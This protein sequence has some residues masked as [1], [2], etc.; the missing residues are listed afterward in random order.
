M[1]VYQLRRDKIDRSFL[2]IHIPKTGGT[3]IERY[4]VSLGLA[5]FF[6]PASYAPI[7]SVLKVPPAHFDYEMCDKLFLLDRIY[8]FAIVRHPVSRM[9]SE[10]RWAIQ[11]SS[12]PEA[13]ARYNF[14][15]YLDF[16]F[17]EYEKDANFLAG[18]LK[19]QRQFVGPKV[20]R[21]FRYETGLNA[22]VTDVFKDTG[23]KPGGKIEVPR[24]NASDRLP[25]TV[26]E[27]D[28]EMIYRLYAED[29]TQFGY[30]LDIPDPDAT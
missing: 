2:F 13:I 11:K 16:A 3:A 4:F 9:I 1:P 14:S 21:V 8:S 28:L 20:S 27:R 19:P 18:H 22:I 17:A 10:Y 24:L 26:T 12:L 25:V 30:K 23:L 15:E 7:R 6:D 5:N 29:F